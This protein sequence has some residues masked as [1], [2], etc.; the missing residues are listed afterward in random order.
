M[1]DT[2]VTERWE[3]FSRTLT[4]YLLSL[5]ACKRLEQVKGNLLVK[6]GRVCKCS[7]QQYFW[8]CQ[9]GELVTQ[10]GQWQPSIESFLCTITLHIWSLV[11]TTTLWGRGTNGNNNN[12]D[13]NSNQQLTFVEHLPCASHWAKLFTWLSHVNLIRPPRGHAKIILI[14]WWGHWGSE[15]SRDRAKL[16]P[17]VCLIQQSWLFI[18]TVYCWVSL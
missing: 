3:W 13:C 16:W 9:N 8:F 7:L 12:Y 17:Q 10:I 11:V 6:K 14:V 15:R 5:E 18:M 4:V 1:S 2:A